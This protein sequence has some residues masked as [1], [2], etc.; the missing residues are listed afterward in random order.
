M[1]DFTHPQSEDCLHLTIW[2]PCADNRRRAVVV[3]LHGGAWQSGAGALDWYDGA[4]LASRGDVVVV[5]PNYRL[6]PLGWL[7]MPGQP[8]NLG[9]LDQEAAL[10][11]VAENISA[12]G[13]DPE[14]IT[15][16]GQSAGAASIACMLARKPRFSRAI[17]QS[18]A[19][20]RPFRG[21]PEASTLANA[22]MEAMG[23]DS[24]EAARRLPVQALLNAQESA[25]VAACV[26]AEGAGRSVYAPVRD[27]TSLPLDMD[28]A[29]HEAAGR[30]DVLI[31]YTAH[32]MAAFRGF[33]LDTHSLEVG[34]RLF[35]EPSLTWA[36]R[37]SDRGRD[38]WI[39][40][41]D[42]APPT[43][44]GACHCLE[45]PFV[46]GTLNHFSSAPMLAGTSHAENIRIGLQMQEEWLAFIHG[47]SPSWAPSPHIHSFH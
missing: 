30:A 7:S 42:Y 31:G 12:F 40:R 34:R 13:G 36:E 37:A 46:F 27:G 6:G 20:G 16:M 18:G 9:L 32:E 19:L 17:I 44:Y 24:V 38:A 10:D 2:T 26:A 33:G 4:Q 39:Y 41:L 47:E 8:H 45:L 29:F 28:Q 43:R 11:W 3:W 23:T 35:E 14:R 1:G 21:V 5:S 25:Q 15:L 22:L